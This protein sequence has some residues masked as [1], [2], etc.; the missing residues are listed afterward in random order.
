MGATMIAADTP[1]STQIAQIPVKR[2]LPAS[3]LTHRVIGCAYQV[4]NHL[5]FG[6]RERYY[7]RAL[8]KSFEL[9]EI[10]F[11]REVSFPI[12]F[13]ESVLGRQQLDFVVSDRLVLELKVGR[14]LSPRF[15]AQVIAYLKVSPYQLA[16][17]LLFTPNGVITKRIIDSHVIEPVSAKSA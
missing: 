14:S 3:E 4:S 2:P 1:I 6:N 11:E 5:G 12:S 13:G 16:L 10:P 9:A 7:Q 8:A 15:T 17:I